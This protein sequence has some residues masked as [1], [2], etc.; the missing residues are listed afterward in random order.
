VPGITTAQG[1]PDFDVSVGPETRQI[2]RYLDRAMCRRKQM[3][4][5]RHLPAAN[6]WRLF[7]TEDLL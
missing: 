7:E 6:A 1:F 3:H 2:A 5:Q 4:E